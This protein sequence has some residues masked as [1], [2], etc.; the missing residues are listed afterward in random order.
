MSD[1]TIEVELFVTETLWEW[2]FILALFVRKFYCPVVHIYFD[3]QKLPACQKKLS[4]FVDLL[5]S[6]KYDFTLS[7]NFVETV[8]DG[9]GEFIPV[10]T[11][12]NVLSNELIVVSVF[13]HQAKSHGIDVLDDSECNTAG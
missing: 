4:F 1:K 2:Q 11:A 10:Q 8:K 9:F 6:F 7:L 12:L 3:H 13:S 5:R